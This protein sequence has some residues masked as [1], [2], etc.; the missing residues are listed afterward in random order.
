MTVLGLDVGN[1]KVKCCLLACDNA[2][3]DLR[4]QTHF[5]WESC[6]LPFSSDR[7]QD[8]ALGLPMAVLG[9]LQ[10]QQLPLKSLQGVVICCS[11]SFSYPNY[12]ESI[13]HL[14]EILCRFLQGLPAWL[15]RADGQLTLLAA[16]AELPQRA[17]YAYTF[18]NFY[19][20]A[21]LGS[22]LIQNGL[23]LDLGTTTL[24]IIP[25]KAGQ[26]DPAGLAPPADPADYLR[27]RY[28]HGRIHWLGLTVIP[29]PALLQRVQLGS[30][31][32]Q[33]VARD[34]RSEVLLALQPDIRDALARQHAYG[35]HFPDP[36]TA[37]RQLAE[38][39]GLD[40]VLLSEAEILALRDQLWQALLARIASE[41]QAV[42]A[43]QFERPL[44]ELDLA[45]FALGEHWALLP[46]LIKAGA[47]PTR[48]RRLELGRDQDLWS[49]S[50]AFAMAVLA[51]EQVS[52]QRVSGLSAQTDA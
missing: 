13:A 3:L 12:A 11:H 1:G 22:R 14:A 43:A 18:T 6:A 37:R 40:D 34:Y 7:R 39:I 50:S 41:I 49:A 25:I 4:Q 48:I 44:A 2:A 17:H 42:A 21:F 24:D 46:A 32:Y 8:F 36:P 47:D 23:S 15:L 31:T 20:S 33:V 45:I 9:F 38:L 19:G 5:A 16:V 27:Y 51:L 26:I 30:E 35:G 29:L 28:S 52:G 10:R